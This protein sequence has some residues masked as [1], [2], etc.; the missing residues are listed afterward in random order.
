MYNYVSHPSNT[1]SQER[2]TDILR[3]RARRSGKS[4]WTS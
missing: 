3:L 2:L 4:V 1:N